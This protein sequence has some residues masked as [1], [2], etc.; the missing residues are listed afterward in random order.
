MSDRYLTH[1]VIEI[2]RELAI[3]SKLDVRQVEMD[4]A[5]RRREANVGK[6]WAL[7]RDRIQRELAKLGTN[8]N[9]W[10]KQALGSSLTTMRL[11]RQLA[12]EWASYVIAR[13]AAGATGQSGLRYGLSLVTGNSATNSRSAGVNIAPGMTETIDTSRCKFITGDALTEFRSMASKSV[14]LIVTSPPYWPLKRAYSGK[15][16]G[17]ED[18]A[19]DYI[20]ALVAVLHEA[21]RVLKDNGVLWIVIGDSYASPGGRHSVE[22]HIAKR[23]NPQMPKMAVGQRIQKGDRPP[24]NLLLVPARLALAMQDDGWVLRQEII[25]DK[26]FARPES[27]QNRVTRTHESIF[28]FAKQATG[29]FYDLN[30]VRVPMVRP[31]SIPGR[32]TGEVARRDLNRDFRVLNNPMGRNAGSVWRSNSAK[33]PGGHTA[34]LPTELVQWILSV[35]CDDDAVVCDP[36]GGS[37]SVALVA[38]QMG[39]RAITIDLHKE[40]TQQAIDRLRRAPAMIPNELTQVAA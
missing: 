11:Y 7:Q 15:G 35:S 19:T 38:L 9:D 2:R 33:Y 36:F 1:I 8:E 32:Q 29:Y 16:I 25:W 22:T 3:A 40:Y 34:P 27:A 20:S 28:M 31:Y 18:T 6:R 39:N 37:G 30:A 23:P 26:D 12:R 4:I 13:R 21:R 24:G 5:A 10:I 17:Y 14:N